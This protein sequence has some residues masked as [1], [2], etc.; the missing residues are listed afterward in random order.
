MWLEGLIILVVIVLALVVGCTCM[1]VRRGGL[2]VAAAALAS[3]P[4]VCFLC[5]R[6]ML[7][8]HPLGWA[9]WAVGLLGNARYCPC[10]RSKLACVLPCCSAVH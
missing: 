10:C 5:C 8:P 2:H 1:H 7:D 9:C 3:C 4:W 6:M